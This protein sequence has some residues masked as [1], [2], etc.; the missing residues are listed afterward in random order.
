MC[1]VKPLKT[2]KAIPQVTTLRL[3]DIDWEQLQALGF[4]EVFETLALFFVNLKHLKVLSVE[5]SIAH[6]DTFVNLVR[7][8]T[9]WSVDVEYLSN[10]V[11]IEPDY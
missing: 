5:K 8:L 1:Q 9:K 7:T 3:I 11:L 4:K 2:I 10:L 6:E